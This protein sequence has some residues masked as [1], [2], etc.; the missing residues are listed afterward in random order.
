MPHPP[1]TA[2]LTERAPEVFELGP[3]LL[4]TLEALAWCA[5]ALALAAGFATL[6]VALLRSHAGRV[7]AQ[8][9]GEERRERIEPLLQRADRL[10]VSAEILE[11]A[12]EIVFLV[13]LYRALADLPGIGDWAVLWTVVGA[14]PLRLVLGEALPTA[15]ALRG[16]DALLLRTLPAFHLLQMPL[17]WLVRSLEGIRA[18]FLRILGLRSAPEDTRQIVEDLREVIADAEITGELDP[19]EREIISNVMTFRDVSISAIMTPRTE[20][21]GVEISAGLAAAARA[22]AETGH[23]RLPVYDGSLDT[24]LGIVTA[25]DVVRVAAEK[26]LDRGSL[27]SIVRPAYFVPETKR[28]SDLLAEFRREKIKVAVVLDEYGGTAGLITLGDIVQEIVGDIQDEFSDARR[29]SLRRL[30]DG[31][32]EVDAGLHV[33]EVNSELDLEIPEG[34]YETLAGFVLAELGHFPQR[35]ERCVH[36]DAEFVV[37]DASDRRVFRVRVRRLPEERAA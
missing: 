3:Q 8:R 4:T 23:S 16:G 35:G 7:L 26:G 6:R 18:A 17:Q 33:T 24:I 19:T 32:V 27:R 22:T 5:P 30:A 29:Q 13:Q 2:H 1:P 12:A 31:W 14:I 15:L 37:V 20:V 11:V 34:D 21:R 10:A 36:G 25:R 9:G 28:V